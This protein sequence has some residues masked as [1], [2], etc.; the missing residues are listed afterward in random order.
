MGESKSVDG[1]NRQLEPDV[2]K[3]G[4]WAFN[5]GLASST[6]S[7]LLEV[8]APIWNSSTFEELYLPFEDG[9]ANE[10]FNGYLSTDKKQND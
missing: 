8:Q 9:S 3:R 6:L 7:S 4:I 5:D 10:E 1:T 2:D